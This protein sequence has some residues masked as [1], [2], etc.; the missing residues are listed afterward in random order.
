MP[1]DRQARTLCK[2]A[3]SV[4]RSG[5]FPHT[6]CVCNSDTDYSRFPRTRR[7]HARQHPGPARPGCRLCRA[8]SLGPDAGHRADAR[9][10]VDH[11]QHHQARPCR[12]GRVLRHQRLHHCVGRSAGAPAARDAAEFRDPAL[13][14]AGAAVLDHVGHPCAAAE[15]RHSRDIRGLAGVRAHQY[16]ARAY[17]GYPALYVGWS[18][19]Y[20]MA[21]YGAFALGLWVAG[22]RA[23]WVVVALFA[24]FTLVLPWWRFGA[25]V[26]TP[27]RAIPLRGRGWRWRAIRWC[28][29]SCSAACSRGPMRA[30]AIG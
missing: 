8:L 9:A 17:Y 13:L 10:W 6:R 22:R 3:R 12:G 20:E 28:W 25:P 18:L 23:L 27:R 21:F 14:P 29:S 1:C 24:A 5:L 19:N 15:P 26:A 4:R 16:G 7:R 11:R 30:G 2:R